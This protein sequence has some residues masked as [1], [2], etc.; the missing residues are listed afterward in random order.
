MSVVSTVIFIGSEYL[1]RDNIKVAFK[2]SG[3]S[4]NEPMDMRLYDKDL[5][6][7]YKVPETDIWIGAFNYFRYREWFEW[8]NEIP[9]HSYSRD[10]TMAIVQSSDL[11]FIKTWRPQ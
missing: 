3:N 7:G 9:W 1:D 4:M 5:A 8:L 2:F 10:E 6:G 11:G